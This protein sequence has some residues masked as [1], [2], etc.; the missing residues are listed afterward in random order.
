MVDTEFDV[1]RLEFALHALA[2]LR[3]EPLGRRQIEIADQ[4]VVTK[5]DVA[6]PE[7]LK[8]L[9]AGNSNDMIFKPNAATKLDP[10][11]APSG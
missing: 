1:D 4:L 5:L 11:R 6:E 8:R 3:S 10:P 9:L 7:A 2:Q